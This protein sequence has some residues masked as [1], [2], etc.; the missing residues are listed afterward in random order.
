MPKDI[1]S[2]CRIWGEHLHYWDPPKKSVLEFLLVCKLCRVLTGTGVGKL[3]WDTQ[4]GLYG[5]LFM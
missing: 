1:Q 3:E 5:I 4:S 2:A